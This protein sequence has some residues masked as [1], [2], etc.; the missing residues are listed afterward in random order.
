MKTTT[1]KLGKGKVIEGKEET[2][3]SETRSSTQ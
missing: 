3:E 2:Q 1:M